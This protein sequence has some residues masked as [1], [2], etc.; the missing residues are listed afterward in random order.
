MA[1]SVSRH[2]SIIFISP[3]PLSGL[4]HSPQK[5][6]TTAHDPKRPH[7]TTPNGDLSRL[8]WRRD[9]HPTAP[10]LSASLHLHLPAPRRC[11]IAQ[12]SLLLPWPRCSAVVLF[13]SQD[14]AASIIASQ[15][16]RSCALHVASVLL[17][18]A[19]REPC[20]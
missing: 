11:R 15:V 13:A 2:G 14:L 18:W 1:P 9:Y 10:R 5:G 20:Q 12:P 8:L 6:R 17:S 16:S 7:S 4:P 19:N 3:P